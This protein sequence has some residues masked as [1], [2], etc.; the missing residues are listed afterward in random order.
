MVQKIITIIMIFLIIIGC[1]IGLFFSVSDKDENIN[2][3]SVFNV[4]DS[5]QTKNV[6]VNEFFTYGRYFNFSGTINGIAKD[7]FENAK[8]F[9]TNRK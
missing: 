1:I 7:N 9:I 8:L 6:E 4:L 3:I 5:V 2:Q